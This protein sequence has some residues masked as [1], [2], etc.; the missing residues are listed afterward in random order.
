MQ[1]KYDEN[2]WNKNGLSIISNAK[3]LKLFTFNYVAQCK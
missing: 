2:G 3:S 1:L